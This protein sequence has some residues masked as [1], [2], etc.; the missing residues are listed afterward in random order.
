M[1]LDGFGNLLGTASTS[2]RS[3]DAAAAIQYVDSAW[4]GGLSRKA[5]WMDLVGDFAGDEPFVIDG[6]SSV[7][8]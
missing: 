4:Y 7:Y 2:L 3:E 1:D 5:R 8:V 6:M